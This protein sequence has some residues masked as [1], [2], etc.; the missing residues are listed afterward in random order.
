[1]LHV[2]TSRPLL[3][4]FG[5]TGYIGSEVVKQAQHHGFDVRVV[6][7]SRRGPN[8]ITS[9]TAG[10]EFIVMDLA[11]AADTGQGPENLDHRALDAVVRGS[12]GVVNSISL[13]DAPH[14][15]MERLHVN[16]ATALA[17]ACRQHDV[18]LVHLSG[19]GADPCSS[20]PYLRVRGQGD[21]A[22]FSA[23][24]LQ[25]TVLRPGAIIGGTTRGLLSSFAMLAKMRVCPLFGLGDTT[26]QPVTLHD[27]AK[28][29]IM[30]CSMQ[31]RKGNAHVP[32]IDVVGSEVMS[33]R[34]LLIDVARHM[35]LTI[36][37]VPLPYPIWSVVASVCANL[38]SAPPIA[39]AQVALMRSPSALRHATGNTSS[40]ETRESQHGRLWQ[41]LWGKKHIP[42]TSLSSSSLERSLPA[43]LTMQEAVGITPEPIGRAVA[44]AFATKVQ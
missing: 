8:F 35:G 14:G 20:D 27:L 39:P 30:S 40:L 42:T 23:N 2:E 15:D 28:T 4:V 37:P 9:S 1:M 36:L 11:Q 34:S 24:P 25:N 29:T 31:T 41:I 26:L 12:A 3:T 22:V 21:A 6:T 44:E 16:G 13:W 38:C 18:P 43:A 17:A 5:G 7:R 33:F 10:V 19:L 32:V